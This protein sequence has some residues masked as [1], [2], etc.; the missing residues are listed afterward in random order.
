MIFIII[1]I[2]VDYISSSFS[3]FSPKIFPVKSVCIFI[4]HFLCTHRCENFSSL[5]P[6][7]LCGSADGDP[8]QCSPMEMLLLAMRYLP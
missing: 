3:L 2:F 5:G 6:D 8:R 1:V 7:P 4:I